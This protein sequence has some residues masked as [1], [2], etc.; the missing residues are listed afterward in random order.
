MEGKLRK[1]SP[2]V[3]SLTTDHTLKFEVEMAD[4]WYETTVSVA[5]PYAIIS[6]VDWASDSPLP[7]PQPSRKQASYNVFAWGIN[8]PAEGERSIV[9]ESYD[10]LASPVGWHTLPFDNDPSYREYTDRRRIEFYRNTTTTWGNNVS[11]SYISLWMVDLMFLLISRFSRMRIGRA[12]VPGS[13]TIA[14]TLVAA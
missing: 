7:S 2:G 6:V 14:R 10:T 12:V 1:C 5:A 11:Y 13:I 4:N 8:D 9:K 3:L